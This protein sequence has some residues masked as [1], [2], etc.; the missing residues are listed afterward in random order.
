MS[1]PLTVLGVALAPDPDELDVLEAETALGLVRVHPGYH[2][3][4][5]WWEIEVGGEVDSA[6]RGCARCGD[7]EA[8]AADADHVL[9]RLRDVIATPLECKVASLE[10][11]LAEQHFLLSTLLDAA[12]EAF[13]R[14]HRTDAPAVDHVSR[15]LSAEDAAEVER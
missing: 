9:T 6:V 15:E 4:M 13:K 2:D 7:V 10:K 11:S 1:A 5:P 12:V 8:A 3:V 14:H